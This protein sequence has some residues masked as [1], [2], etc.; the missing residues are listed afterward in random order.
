MIEYT[1]AGVLF[2]FGAISATRSIREPSADEDGG[3]RF[4]FAVHDAAKALFW[5]SLGGFFL[6]YRVTEGA[7]VARW[8]LLVPIAM[9][10]IR[11]LAAQ[12]LSRS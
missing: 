3:D 7:A 12:L 11:L 2:L 4:L 1:A 10:G 9:A 6:A 8:V 5:F